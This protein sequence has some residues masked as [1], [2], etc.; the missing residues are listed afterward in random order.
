LE[1]Y[2]FLS[3]SVS[4]V[5]NTCKLGLPLLVNND[6][7]QAKVILGSLKEKIMK[8]KVFTLVMIGLFGFA[9]MGFR[10]AAQEGNGNGTAVTIVKGEVY[11]TDKGNTWDEVTF[12]LKNMI[13]GTDYIVY[14]E[15]FDK[16]GRSLGITDQYDPMV[17]TKE[18]GTNWYMVNLEGFKV[19]HEFTME[20]HV[21]TGSFLGS[22]SSTGTFDINAAPIGPGETV[23]IVKYP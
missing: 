11:S 23:L 21:Y 5:K 2:V 10:P 22:L 7:T 17:S 4:F 13:P 9:S 1:N 8:T 12:G 14:I 19:H 15:F 3:K 6:K 18:D 20:V 16:H